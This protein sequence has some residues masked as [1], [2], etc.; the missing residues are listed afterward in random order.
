MQHALVSPNLRSFPRI[1]MGIPVSALSTG[2][3]SF[4]ILVLSH[5][6]SHTRG[7]VRISAFEAVTSAPLSPAYLG[8]R[9]A[10]T[11]CRAHPPVAVAGCSYWSSLD[12][13][14]KLETV[15]RWAGADRSC[16]SGIAGQLRDGCTRPRKNCIAAHIYATLIAPSY[17]SNQSL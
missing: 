14:A 6:V 5:P 9:R 3:P 16:R 17:R 10:W 1:A 12:A 15:F 4:L 7:D 2:T 13:S 8:R 11:P